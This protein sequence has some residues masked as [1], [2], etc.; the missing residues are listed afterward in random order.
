MSFAANDKW[1]LEQISKICKTCTCTIRLYSVASSLL[2][3]E[4]IPKSH[5]CRMFFTKQVLAVFFTAIV[6]TAIVL[7]TVTTVIVACYLLGFAGTHSILGGNEY[8]VCLIEETSPGTTV[9]PPNT[10]ATQFTTV[11]GVCMVMSMERKHDDEEENHDQARQRLDRPR[12]RRLKLC[13]VSTL[14]LTSLS[15]EPLPHRKPSRVNFVD[16]DKKLIRES[17]NK[18]RKEQP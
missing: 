12:L 14:S 13:H 18:A 7:I 9:S 3:S 6:F 1:L 4:A 17:D 5:T 11:N 15:Q 16:Q 10:S 2:F 8:V